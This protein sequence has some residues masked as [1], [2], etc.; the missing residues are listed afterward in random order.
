MFDEKKFARDK[1]DFSHLLFT[2]HLLIW[3]WDF[4]INAFITIKKG[5]K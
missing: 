5:K 4:V 2:G 1:I 3:S